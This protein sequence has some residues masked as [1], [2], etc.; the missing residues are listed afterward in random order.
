MVMVVL[1]VVGVGLA[2]V[3]SLAH[4]MVVVVMGAVMVAMAVAARLRMDSQRRYCVSS[5]P[6]RPPGGP[7]CP[8]GSPPPSRPTPRPRR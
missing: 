2:G 3:E 6:L 5:T 1:V 4:T 8:K 7:I